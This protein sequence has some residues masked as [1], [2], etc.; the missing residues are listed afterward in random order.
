MMPTNVAARMTLAGRS[1]LARRARSRP[2]SSA[3]ARSSS[4]PPASARGCS[5][6]RSARCWPGATRRRSRG[7][8]RSS[9]HDAGEER[10]PG[11]G[12]PVHRPVDPRAERILELADAR[13]VTAPHVSLARAL[14]DAVAEAWEKPLPM[15]VALPIAAVHARSRLSGLGGQGRSR[16]SRAPPACS[17]TSP[18]SRRTR[19]ASSSRGRPRR[20][21]GT[22]RRAT[23]DARA[24]GRGAP[25]GRAARARRRELPRAARVPPRALAVLSGEARRVPASSPPRTRAG[26]RTS[27]GCRSRRSPSSRRRRP[28]DNPARHASLRRPGRDRPH[29]LDERHDGHAEL[30]PAHGGRPRQLGHRLGAELRGLGHL[31]RASGS[32]RRTTPGRSSPERRSRPSTGSGSATSR[33]APGTPSG[34]LA[35]IELLRPEAAVLTPSYAAYLV[36]WAAERGLDLARLERRA[37]ARR[38]RA[39]WRRARLP[40]AARGGLGRARHRGHGHRRHRHLALGRVRGAGRHAPRCARLRPSRADRSR[41]GRVRSSWRTARRASSSS[42]ISATAPLRSCASAPA[43]TSRCGRSPCACGRTGPRVRCIGRTDDMLIVR[44]VNVFPSAVREVVGAFAPQ[45][46]GHIRVRPAGG[47][48]EAGAAAARRRRAGA[49]TAR[50]MP[51]SRTRSVRDCAPCS[52]SRRR[53]ELVPWGSLARSEY[54]ST[55]VER[56]AMRKL[57][58]QGVHHITINGANRQTSIDF[59]E[60]VLGMPFVFEQPNLDNASESH[61]Y[62][63][64]GDGRLITVFTNEERRAAAESDAAGAGLRAPP[65]V[66]AFAGDASTRRW[67]GS[68]S[69]GSST[70]AS[71]TAASWT[72]STSTIR[73]AFWSSSRPTASSRPPAT[74][75]P[76]CCSRR[77]SFAS[78]AATRNIDRVHLAD[79]I[80]LLV[81]RSQAS[82][83]DDRSPKNPY[84]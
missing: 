19:S 16:S 22:S 18:R 25:V 40:G 27:R 57:Q 62:F 32:S 66:R 49:A 79:A 63:D 73:S 76:M 69:A 35:A 14:R 11:F 75:T 33:S 34:S 74:R 50:P 37:R 5:R 45:V 48:R 67:S 77:T 81:S 47:G 46:S 56:V 78:S 68:T 58:T 65:R 44:G 72:R 6:T 31:R 80:E 24:G 17:R 23:G 15:N 13:G 61:L 71:R 82:L 9:I 10:C 12:H 42:R 2:G 4:A 20:P 43:T 1:G 39:G 53:V 60:G 28:P 41:D 26:W 83:S 51:S 8:P 3:R 38:G 30:H 36:E 54:K 70:R 21:I 52:S 29:L 84:N 7:R 55:L 59:W 64:P